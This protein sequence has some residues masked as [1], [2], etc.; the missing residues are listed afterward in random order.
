MIRSS[1]CLSHQV[2]YAFHQGAD[3]EPSIFHLPEHREDD[4]LGT[5]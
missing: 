4:H 2:T 1:L 5:A 3:D